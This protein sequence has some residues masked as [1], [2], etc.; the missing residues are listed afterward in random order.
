MKCPK[1]RIDQTEVYGGQAIKHTYMR[2]RRCLACGYK[3]KTIERIDLDDMVSKCVCAVCKE[4]LYPDDEY[5]EIDDR[6]MCENCA[7]EWLSSQKNWVTEDM[8]Y[9]DRFDDV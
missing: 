7:D 3:F 1:C 2:Y 5:Y 8:A 9:G 4:M 6:I